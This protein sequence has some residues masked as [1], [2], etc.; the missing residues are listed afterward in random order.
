MLPSHNRLPG[1]RIPP[2]LQQGT[3][4][5]GHLLSIITVPSGIPTQPSRFTVIVPYRLSKI[6]VKRNRTRRLIREAVH[7]HLD[8]T[9]QGFDVI[10]MAQTLLLTTS[11]SEIEEDVRSLFARAHIL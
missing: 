10:V 3:R 5:S 7:H 2:I 4:T 1:Y 8:K 11:L 9:I 6:A